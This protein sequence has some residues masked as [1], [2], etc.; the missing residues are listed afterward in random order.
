MAIDSLGSLLL[1]WF[2][3]NPSMDKII[4][5][6]IKSGME[7]LIRW[8]LGKDKLFHPTPY[9]ACNYLSMVK[10]KLNYVS[11]RG[12]WCHFAIQITGVLIVCLTVCSGADQRN[13]QSST[14]LAFVRETTSDWWIPFIKG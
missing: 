12:P 9:W 6:I 4:T 2:N 7:L 11:K 10:L 1:T 13:H 3:F 8:N 14:S 5:F